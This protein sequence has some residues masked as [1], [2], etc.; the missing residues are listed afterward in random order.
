MPAMADPDSAGEYLLASLPIGLWTE[1]SRALSRNPT[2]VQQYI[3]RGKP[4]YL[5]DNDR[6]IL[7][8]LY[9]LDPAR[10]RPPVK[11]GRR[12]GR[13]P[14]NVGRQHLVDADL[15]QILLDTPQAAVLLRAFA[16]MSPTDQRAFLRLAR[17]I[18]RAVVAV[19]PDNPGRPA[20]ITV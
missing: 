4:L 10:L 3:R 12:L 2:Y 20:A 16:G 6:R 11:R 18:P 15:A 14:E 19:T 7:V 5:S 8:R 9:N 17:S 13:P 1:A